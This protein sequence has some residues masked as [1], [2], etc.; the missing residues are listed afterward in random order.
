[1]KFVIQRVSNAS[2]SI[3]GNVVGKIG[4]GYMI[5]IGIGKEDTTKEADRLVDKMLKMR[6]FDDADGKTNLSLADVGG[7]LLLISQFTLYADCRKGN[8]PSFINAA[9]PDEAERL[10]EYVISK[11]K[12]QVSNVQTGSFGADMQVELT[13]SGPFTIVLDSSIFA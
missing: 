11:C 10:Y 4:K 13:N 7:E 12:E 5:L 9:P 1:M 2:V 3:E 8:R 6:I